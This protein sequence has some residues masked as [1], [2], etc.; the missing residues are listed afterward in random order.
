MSLMADGGAQLKKSQTEPERQKQSKLCF[1][2]KN[3][4][5][6]L[7]VFMYRKSKAAWLWL[8]SSK[9]HICENHQIVIIDIIWLFAQKPI[10]D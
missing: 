2:I 5:Q 4:P 8:M 10:L 6:I 9:L 1:S 7:W 3:G